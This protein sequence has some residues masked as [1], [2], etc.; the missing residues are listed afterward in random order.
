[1]FYRFKAGVRLINNSFFV[2]VPFLK[3]LG[4][5]SLIWFR[6]KMIAKAMKYANIKTN[7]N[8]TIWTTIS[9]DIL[10]QSAIILCYVYMLVCSWGEVI[11]IHWGETKRGPRIPYHWSRLFAIFF[12]DFSE[13]KDE[14]TRKQ[15]EIFDFRSFSIYLFTSWIFSD[16]LYNR[17]SSKRVINKHI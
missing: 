12:Y 7:K 15:P 4:Q 5:S 9:D 11:P 17:N 10:F 6:I 14:K 13:V 3:K 8:S 2:S 16:L 1:M